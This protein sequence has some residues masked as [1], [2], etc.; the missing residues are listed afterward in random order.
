MDSAADRGIVP[1][2][3]KKLPGLQGKHSYDMLATV[4]RTLHALRDARSDAD[5]TQVLAEVVQ[6]FGY[7]SG[8]LIE[9]ANEVH[10]LERV[11]DTDATRLAWWPHYFASDLRPAAHQVLKMLQT[12]R[13]LYL[14][15]TRFGP[16]PAGV[17]EAFETHDLVD[18]A[19]VPVNYAGEMV[20]V[21]GFVGAVTLDAEREMA[22]Q[23]ISYAFFSEL[24]AARRPPAR[25]EGVTLTP[26]EKE[27]ITLSADG[28]TSVEIAARLGMS[29]RTANQH[30][31]NVADKLGTRNRAHT[32]AEVIRRNLLH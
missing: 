12:D 19:T 26:R 11:I 16:G 29:P 23:L 25:P 1:G 15:G 8:Y 21:A 3:I 20:G 14:D 27:V 5:I 10:A 13:V 2:R 18:L 31:D 9:Y 24:R 28:L 4:E 7:R 17:R 30:V 6:R 32:V 22:L